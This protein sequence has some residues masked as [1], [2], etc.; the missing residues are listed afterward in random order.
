MKFPYQRG[1]KGKGIEVVRIVIGDKIL[2]VPKNNVFIKALEA[3]AYLREVSEDEKEVLII[4][5]L[6]AIN[7]KSV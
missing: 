5:E 4:T 1:R 6:L 3:E 7:Y 2:S